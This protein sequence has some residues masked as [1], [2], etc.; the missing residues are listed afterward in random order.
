[1]TREEFQSQMSRLIKVYGD[2]AYPPER[3]QIIWRKIQFRHPKIFESSVD[4]LIAD[5]A[6][7]PLLS[8]IMEM[9]VMVGKQYPD[10]DKGPETDLR[11]QLIEAQKRP[12]GCDKCENWGV[13]RAFRKDKFGHPEEYLLCDCRLGSIA[14]RLPEYRRCGEW[15]QYYDHYYVLDSEYQSSEKLALFSH[16]PTL[17][18]ERRMK[19]IIR[20]ME[21]ERTKRQ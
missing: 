3:M 10:L 19:E 5:N 20:V 6:H 8:K 1:M 11:D 13:I 7:P 14:A 21:E 2:R 18:E 4:A 15:H 16:I 17:P 9:L 12:G